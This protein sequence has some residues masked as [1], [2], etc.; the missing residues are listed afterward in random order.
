LGVVHAKTGKCLVGVARHSKLELS[1]G[2]VMQDLHAK[3]RPGF[4]E[5]LDLELG[6]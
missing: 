2:L 6:E 1:G 4:S 5:V 3:Y